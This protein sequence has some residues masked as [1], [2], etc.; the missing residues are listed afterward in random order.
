MDRGIGSLKSGNH[1]QREEVFFVFWY[2]IKVCFFS[3]GMKTKREKRVGNLKRRKQLKD[4]SITY[5]WV[6]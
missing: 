3:L 4:Y 6:L 5:F 1:T 2:G